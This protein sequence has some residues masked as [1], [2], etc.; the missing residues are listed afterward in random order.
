MTNK[1]YTDDGEQ[2]VDRDLMNAL[3]TDALS[4]F[5]IDLF[6]VTLY[7]S[8]LALVFREGSET[9]ILRIAGSLYTN[10]G[11]Q[12]LLGS[13]LAA[14]LLYVQIRLVATR[15]TY[16]NRGI[17]ND[18]KMM[19]YSLGA[20]ALG[21]VLAVFLLLAG[22][23]DGLSGGGVPA[24]QVTALFF[25]LWLIV[26]LFDSLALPVLVRRWGRQAREYMAAWRSSETD[27]INMEDD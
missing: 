17:V 9:F 25:Q 12:F 2:P 26:V 13:M 18:E 15:D 20:T 14:V 7:A 27:E 10:F 6:V 8:I 24:I 1:P 11:F 3:A 4:V 21:S 16:R 19:T 5:R 22:V 23:L